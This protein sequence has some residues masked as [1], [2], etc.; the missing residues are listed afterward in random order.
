[1]TSIKQARIPR[2]D[3]SGVTVQIT[4]FLLES[5]FFL[6]YCLL[7]TLRAHRVLSLLMEF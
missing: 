2:V 5:L 6:R 1:M 3:L 4:F 7:D